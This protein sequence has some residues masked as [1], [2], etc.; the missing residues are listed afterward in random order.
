LNSDAFRF[1][2]N[3]YANPEVRLLTRR[4]RCSKN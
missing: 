1:E 4:A 2:L 3:R